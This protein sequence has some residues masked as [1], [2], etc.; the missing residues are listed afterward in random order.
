[1]DTNCDRAATITASHD[2]WSQLTVKIF[3]ADSIDATE[4]EDQISTIWL[5]T[6]AYTFDED[7]VTSPEFDDA[8]YMADI[9]AALAADGWTVTDWLAEHGDYG[10]IV[11]ATVVKTARKIGDDHLAEPHRR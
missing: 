1:M 6:T 7:C 2:D 9:E 10:P 5:T 8:Q 3:E 11:G 4:G